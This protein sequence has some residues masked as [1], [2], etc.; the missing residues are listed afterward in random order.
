MNA[1]QKSHDQNPL[2]ARAGEVWTSFKQGKVISY[3][4]MAVILL[5][6]A[7]IGTTIYIVYE[8]RKSNSNLWV[9]LEEANSQSAFEEIAKKNPDTI[10]AQIARLNIARNQ[11]GPAGIDRLSGLDQGGEF[12][13]EI[14]KKAIES[15]ESAR[16]TLGKLIDEFKD[17]PAL[18]ATCIYAMAMSEIALVAVPTKEVPQS[19]GVVAPTEFKGSIEKVVEWLDKLAAAV[20]PE[21]PWATDA[22]AL[23]DSLRDKTSPTAHDFTRVQQALFR[24]G[25]EPGPGAGTQPIL[26]G[27]NHPG[28]IGGIPRGPLTPPGVPEPPANKTEKAPETSPPGSNIAPIPT[29][30]P[31]PE[32]E[33]T[34]PI[35]PPKAPDSKTPEPTPAPKIAEPKAPSKPGE[36]TPTPTTPPDKK[37]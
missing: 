29:A 7:V 35:T 15:I 19:P 34:T 26:P 20:P 10:Q 22:K 8:R 28:P 14:R 25:I 13:P 30:P 6:A 17:Q 27:F 37:P 16:E 33:S 24:P 9:A 1:D 36:P 32:K 2:S 3:K 5:L 18:K 31:K 12:R 4:V 21:S 23:A 11:L